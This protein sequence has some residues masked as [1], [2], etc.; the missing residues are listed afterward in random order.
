ML[1]EMDD[2]FR[3]MPDLARRLKE[4]EPVRFFCEGVRDLGNSPE[5][6]FIKMNARGRLLTDWE[7]FK[8][9]FLPHL[10][11]KFPE[12]AKDIADKLDND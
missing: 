4:K 10:R 12:R 1:D 6:I 2:T 3:D 5:E 9:Q 11:K 8:A 7:H